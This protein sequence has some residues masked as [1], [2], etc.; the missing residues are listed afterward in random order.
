MAD[1]G[2]QGAPQRQWVLERRRRWAWTG[3]REVGGGGASARLE[4]CRGVTRPSMAKLDRCRARR[5]YGLRDNGCGGLALH[6]MMVALQGGA[7]RIEPDCCSRPRPRLGPSAPSSTREHSPAALGGRTAWP[8]CAAHGGSEACSPAG[9]KS[10]TPSQ[11][12]F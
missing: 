2:L 4:I 7:G 10:A 9:C 1:S 6:G 12:R 8:G 3:G 11:T 5:G